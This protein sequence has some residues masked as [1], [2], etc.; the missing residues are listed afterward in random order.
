M[1]QKNALAQLSQLKND[2]RSSKDIANG[3]VRGTNGKF[4]FVILEDGR[5]A[6][7]TPNDMNRLFPGDEVRINV[8]EGK[9]GKPQAELEKLLNSELSDFVGKYVVKGQGHFVEPDMPQFS[10]WLFIPPKQRKGLKAGDLIHCKVSQHPFHKDGKAQVE[11]L[12]R[13]GL[14][15]DAGIEAAYMR[16][17]FSLAQGDEAQKNKQ[18][19]ELNNSPLC[20]KHAEHPASFVTIDGANT[21]DM[22]DAIEAQITDT[23][24]KLTVAIADPSAE[25]A[26]SSPI[27][28]A[29]RQRMQ[30]VYLPASTVHMLPTSLSQQRYSLVEGSLRHAIICEMQIDEHGEITEYAFQEG[31]IQSKQKLSYQQVSEFLESGE[32]TEIATSLH[33]NLQALEKLS[34]CRQAYRQQHALVMEDKADYELNINDNGKIESIS[35]TEKNKAH[36]LVEEAMLATNICAANLFSKHNSKALFTQHSGFKDDKLKIISE[37]LEADHPSLA[38]ADLT[39]L[40]GYTTLIRELE[41]TDPQLYLTCKRLL[42]SSALTEDAAPHLGLGL[43]AYATITSPIRRYQD[44]YNQLVI[45]QIL[46]QDDTQPAIVDL[47]KSQKQL[48][49][50]RQAVRQMEQWLQCQYMQ[51]KIGSE[52]QATIALVNGQGVGVRFDDTGIEGFVMLQ[53]KENP[54]EL[55]HRRLKLVRGD[56]VLQLG[57]SL[58]VKVSSIDMKMRR[59]AVEW[60][61]DTA[62][63][64]QSV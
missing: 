56:T 50:G 2:I 28:I 55:D 27:A 59:I 12:E 22:D 24:F 35:K 38:D 1:L 47:A 21:L 40:D 11:V 18:E 52:H 64:A 60:V 4:G 20:D 57:Q 49:R 14:E 31:R 32:S 54:W 34:N 41:N 48:G 7:V 33:A 9:A 5:E 3:I 23:G 43:P 13:L 45:K 17:K 42:Q 26:P 63:E 29:A 46:N 25:I 19:A 53:N 62:Q 15:S 39:T 30:S 16:C 44:Y 36:K 8:V 10:R 6:F 51:D 37:V 61:Q 58:T